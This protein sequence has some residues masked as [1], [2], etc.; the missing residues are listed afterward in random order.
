MKHL[1]LILLTATFCASEKK[2]TSQTFNNTNTNFEINQEKLKSKILFSRKKDKDNGWS[3]YA[4]NPDG[5]KEE[6]IIPF[7]SGQGE[8]NPNVSVNGYS[9]L[10]NTYRYGG[11]KLAAFDLETKKTKRITT[12]SNYFY[13]GAYSPNEKKITYEKV[14]RGEKTKICIADS[15]GQNETVITN[16]MQAFENRVPVWTPDGKSVIFYNNKNS[17]NDIYIYNVLDKSITNLTNNDGGNDF[18]PSVSP[19]G[20]QVAYFSDRNGFL[21]VY[22]MDINGKNQ[23]CITS[24]LRSKYNEYNFYKDSN[25]FWVFKISWSPNGNQ[26]VFSNTKSNN[27]DLFTINKDGTGLRQITFTPKSE[28]TPVWG[29]INM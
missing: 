26:L 15:N 2:N 18:N 22:I 17:V 6:V 13:N 24:K 14:G 12:T 19:D 5:T 10:F 11:W 20:K 9:I 1:F 25:L 4:I 21:D 28:Y 27:T 8:Y 7:K 23:V 3:I 16:S 29:M